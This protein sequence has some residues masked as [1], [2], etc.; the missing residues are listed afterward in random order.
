[1]Q[2]LLWTTM[3]SV[4]LMFQESR[5]YQITF[6]DCHSPKTLYRYERQE[7]CKR[8]TTS[9]EPVRR[10]QVLQ[11][12]KIERLSGYSCSVKFSTFVYRCGTWSHLKTA[13][14]PQIDHYETVPISWCHDLAKRRKFKTEHSGASYPLNWD[15]WNI[16]PQVEKGS[17][18]EDS[19]RVVCTGETYHS[20]NQIH[21]NVVVLKE[22]KVLIRREDFVSDGLTMEVK[23]ASLSL[24]C[25]LKQNGC[26]TGQAT[27]IWDRKPNDCPLHI[28]RE[29]KAQ[30]TMNSY[31]VDESSK[32][33]LNITGHTRLIGCDF[34]LL[35]T[36][37]PSLYLVE[38]SEKLSLPDLSPG[39]LD[40][41]M[42]G[43]IARDYIEYNEEMREARMRH[44]VEAAICESHKH[45][46]TDR[47]VHLKANKF[48]M[49]RGDIIITFECVNQTAP[50]AD[51]DECYELIPIQWN[52]IKFVDPASRVLTDHATP[53]ACNVHFPLTIRTNELWVELIPHVKTI[54][55]PSNPGQLK[56]DID[57]NDL[58]GQNL[59]TNKEVDAWKRFLEFPSYHQAVLKTLTW[60]ACAGDDT[61]QGGSTPGI[62]PMS[63]D[64]LIQQT[65][66]RL[67]FWNKIT[68]WIRSYGD[69][70]ALMVIVYVVIKMLIH[71]VILTLTL[72]KEGPKAMIA[73][74]INLYLSIHVHYNKIRRRNQRLRKELHQ[75]PIEAQPEE[76]LPLRLPLR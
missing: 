44:S 24:P 10:F 70:M 49:S 48:S 14:V 28:I 32:V 73:L 38:Q 75:Q 6:Y 15:T 54:E 29:M 56:A 53:I 57:H 27:Y 64:S 47:P 2:L 61:C 72:L 67:N 40:I 46:S 76:S 21:T 34:E 16:I 26:E 65:T 19:D 37:Y 25:G 1:M 42:E 51:L 5:A 30:T 71:I 66:E 31:V 20:N 18:F 9:T 68:H 12:E 8:Q 33:L 35:K 11:E 39:E 45:Q 23:S 55:P 22:Y 7:I 43:R 69:T 58:S 36:N 52:G 59:Y 74:M 63:L 60:G 50:L 62:Q 41:E 13:L 3:L 17:L 4:G